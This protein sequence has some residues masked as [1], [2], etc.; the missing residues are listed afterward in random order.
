MLPSISIIPPFPLLHC[1]YQIAIYH[2]ID[3]DDIVSEICQRF[4]TYC[5]GLNF[6]LS[7]FEACFVG[8]HVE[9]GLV[10]VLRKPSLSAKRQR[11]NVTWDEV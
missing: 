6:I 4:Q 10:K 8:S 9:E 5:F 11:D 1:F 7:D 2:P 3:A